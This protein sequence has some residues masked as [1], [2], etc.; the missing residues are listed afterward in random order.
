V[1]GEARRSSTG[2]HGRLQPPLDPDEL[3]PPELEPEIPEL[4]PEIPELDPLTPELDPEIPELDP[5]TPE[6]DPVT[7]ELDPLTPEL[8]PALPELDPV[9]PLP[10]PPEPPGSSTTGPPPEVEPH[11]ATRLAETPRTTETTI[12][13]T[14]TIH[15]TL[16]ARLQH[17]C[18]CRACGRAALP[19]KSDGKTRRARGLLASVRRPWNQPVQAACALPSNTRSA[20]PERPQGVR[21]ARSAR[22]QRPSVHPQSGDARAQTRSA[23]PQT[24][25]G[26]A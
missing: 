15:L 17:Q 11:A 22:T 4:D 7:P 9:E 5:L 18:R 16:R 26:R 8:D 2:G 23:R 21:E 6:L 12:A 14:F 1:N 3:A 13:A 25:K 24:E 19:A 10:A 20:R